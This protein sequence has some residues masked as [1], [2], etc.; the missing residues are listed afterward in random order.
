MSILTICICIITILVSYKFYQHC[1]KNMHELAKETCPT[2]FVIFI[3]FVPIFNL[4]FGVLMYF[5][6]VNKNMSSMIDK[7]FRLNK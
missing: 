6:F 1:F 5:M 4:I 2:L 3:M 7:F